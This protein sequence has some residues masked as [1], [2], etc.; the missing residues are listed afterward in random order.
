MWIYG[1]R[2]PCDS[3]VSDTW[4]NLIKIFERCLVEQIGCIFDEN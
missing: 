4:E 1:H 2:N 3:L